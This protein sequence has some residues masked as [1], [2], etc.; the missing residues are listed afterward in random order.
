MTVVIEQTNWILEIQ[1]YWN[2]WVETTKVTMCCVL[3][4][5][6]CWTIQEKPVICTIYTLSFKGYSIIL[7]IWK[8]R[9]VDGSFVQQTVFCIS[10]EVVYLFNKNKKLHTIVEELIKLVIVKT[11]EIMHGLE[12]SKWLNVVAL[13]VKMIKDWISNLVEDVWQQMIA[14]IIACILLSNLRKLDN[15]ILTHSVCTIVWWG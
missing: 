7:K 4:I 15:W 12:Y 11:D 8:K 3:E 10:L 5:I 9:F 1:V 13:S 14:S 6:T 2:K